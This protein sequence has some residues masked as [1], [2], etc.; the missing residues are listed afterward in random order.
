MELLPVNKLDTSY[1]KGFRRFDYTVL[2]RMTW[3][4]G[5]PVNTGIR[6]GIQ[7]P[8]QLPRKRYW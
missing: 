5:V 1:V 6:T 4:L 7:R 2:R 3:Y 8:W